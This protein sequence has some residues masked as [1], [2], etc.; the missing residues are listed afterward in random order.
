MM[1]RTRYAVSSTSSTLLADRQKG[2]IRTSVGGDM[3]EPWE[4]DMAVTGRRPPGERSILLDR[5]PPDGGV[6]TMRPFC[7]PAQPRTPTASGH[8]L[9]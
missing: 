3:S 9:V 5:L 6:C 8:S 4:D 1:S 7:P 2:H